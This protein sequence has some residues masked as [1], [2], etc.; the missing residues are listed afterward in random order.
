M[1]GRIS[2]NSKRGSRDP[3]TDESVQFL[4]GECR[5]PWT[6][7]SAQFFKAE[8]GIHG[9]PNQSKFL[10]TADSGRLIQFEF[11]KGSTDSQISPN[12]KKESSDGQTGT[13]F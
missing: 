12:L 4:K 1:D 5:D 13:N 10:K 6:T 7:E 8:A 2:P 9:R 11:K 3:W